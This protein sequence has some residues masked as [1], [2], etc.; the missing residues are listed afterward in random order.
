MLSEELLPLQEGLYFMEC[1][2]LF[3]IVWFSYNCESVVFVLWLL[4][5]CTNNIDAIDFLCGVSCNAIGT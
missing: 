2:V 5:S 3:V 1:V 4:M